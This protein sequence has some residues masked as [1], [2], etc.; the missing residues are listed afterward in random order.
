MNE[1]G[2]G[3]PGWQTNQSKVG[4]TRV[5]WQGEGTVGKTT[6]R[7]WK[8][9]VTGGTGRLLPAAGGKGG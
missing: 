8:Q 3:Q 6:G 4:S 7:V 1:E 9:T 5:E 2:G